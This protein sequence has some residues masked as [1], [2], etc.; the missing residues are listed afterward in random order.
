[1]IAAD[2]LP[3]CRVFPRLV[4]ILIWPRARGSRSAKSVPSLFV[5]GNATLYFGVT[6][7]DHSILYYNFSKYWRQTTT[8]VKTC[9]LTVVCW[10]VTTSS[11]ASICHCLVDDRIDATFSMPKMAVLLARKH[12]LSH[13]ACPQRPSIMTIICKPRIRYLLAPFLVI[14]LYSTEYC[15]H[16]WTRPWPAH[17]LV[18]PRAWKAGLS[19]M[20]P[21]LP[22]K[23]PC[24]AI[25]CEI[26][27][28]PRKSMRRNVEQGVAG[29]PLR[30]GC[31]AVASLMRR[32]KEG[33]MT[34]SRL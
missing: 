3:S 31:I 4:K 32:T 2:P 14:Y 8:R 26:P 1:M 9:T 5:C 7:V 23:L 27:V 13:G 11:V 33:Y 28:T 12:L 34:E 25:M 19:P 10:E 30:R 20:G 16:P 29:A 6:G 17:S 22:W 18:Y 24:L 15:R 21:D